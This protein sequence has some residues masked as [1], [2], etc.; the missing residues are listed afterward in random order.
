MTLFEMGYSNGVVSLH[1]LLSSAAV[2]G[3]A[4]EADLSEITEVLCRG[5]VALRTGGR[6]LQRDLEFLG[7]LFESLVVRDLRVYAGV[8]DGEVFHYRDNTGLEVDT[9]VETA[10]GEWFAAEIELGGDKAIDE[11][12]GSLLKLR[13]KVDTTTVGEPAKLVVITAVGGYCYD[14]PDGVAVVPITALGP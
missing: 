13:D 6:R 2:T 7:L 10:G 4:C 12:A 5:V 14:R 11:A 8:H 9:V 1:S 3:R